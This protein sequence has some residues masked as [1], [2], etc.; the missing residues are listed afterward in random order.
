MST[1]GSTPRE[2]VRIAI[3]GTVL[4][5][6]GEEL[7]RGLWENGVYLGTDGLVYH[8][9]ASQSRGGLRKK[10]AGKR[11]VGEYLRW[12]DGLFRPG[13]LPGEANAIHYRAARKLRELI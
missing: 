2:P 1:S 12:V 10:I 7:M 11:A 3:E 9:T 8:I 4:G 5:F 6:E 13:Q